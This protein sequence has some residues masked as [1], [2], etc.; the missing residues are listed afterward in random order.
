MKTQ[1]VDATGKRLGKIATHVA[2]LLKG[3]NK[4]SYVPN[5]VCGDK[6]VIINIDDLDIDPKKAKGKKYHHYS[7]YPGG[8]TSITLQKLFKKDSRQVV[9]KAIYGMLP[10]NKLR[11]KMLRNLELYKDGNTPYAKKDELA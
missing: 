9:R 4:A 3:K 10:K 2:V 1:I 6:V 7:G 11:T 5:V 8:I